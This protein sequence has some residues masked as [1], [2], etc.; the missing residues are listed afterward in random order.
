MKTPAPAPPRPPV[1]PRR[2]PG[3]PRRRPL[4]PRLALGAL[5]LLLA[6]GAGHAVLWRMMANQ[7]EAGLAT[8]VQIR[9]AQGWRV[10]HA[11]PVRG[12]WPFSAT[13]TLGAVRLEGGGATV[14]GGLVLEA[15]RVVLRVTLPRLNRLRVE[16]PGAQRLRLAGG[17]WRFAADELVALLPLEADTPPRE[18]V[19]LAERLRL[20]TPAG[21]MEVGSA[22]LAA[23]SSSTATEAEPAITLDLSAE[24][25]DLPVAA[26]AARGFG[27]RIEAVLAELS[28]SGPM[29]LGRSAPA[30][31]AEAW[32][33]AGGSLE[34]RQVALRWGPAEVAAA[35]T[36][37][38]DE[39]LQPMGAGTLRVTGAAEA[40][41]ALTDAGVVGRRA[42]GTARIML[43]L[44][45]RPAPG[46]GTEIEVPVTV[47]DRTLAIARI[48]VLRF[49][50]WDWPAAAAVPR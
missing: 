8:W 12:G 15:E 41:Q 27:R 13:L 44:M 49:P 7:L 6:L 28:L 34:L 22:R 38:L 14:P 40:L 37:A 25:I 36:L 23:A 3:A 10:D 42:A 39:A 1:A 46:G 35:A 17:E 21:P 33:D 31:R 4:G 29:P 16:M 43:P 45:S 11:P 18:A 9:Q 19:F 20:S 50:T 2:H 5:L 32:R 47:E 26:D 24:E 48:P 30:V